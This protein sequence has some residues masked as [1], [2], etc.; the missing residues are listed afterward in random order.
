M[1]YG[2]CEC[3]PDHIM[4]C[5]CQACW[6]RID[7]LRVTPKLATESK[8]RHDLFHVCQHY[9][10]SLEIALTAILRDHRVL[11]SGRDPGCSTGRVF[12]T[13]KKTRQ[14][15]NWHHRHLSLRFSKDF[16]RG[17]TQSRFFNKLIIHSVWNLSGLRGVH[18]SRNPPNTSRAY[19]VRPRKLACVRF[20]DGSL[21]YFMRF[22]A[23]AVHFPSIADSCG[24]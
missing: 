16:D 15:N 17:D 1:V 5:L 9:F 14:S 13:W 19:K 18:H 11:S 10:S 23:G 3:G 8:T 24:Q 20:R 4:H 2:Q 21:V 7:R 12:P 6:I 22:N